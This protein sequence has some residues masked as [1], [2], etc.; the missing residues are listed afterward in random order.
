MT[1]LMR[2]VW[3][4]LKN[5]DVIMIRPNKLSNSMQLKKVKMICVTAL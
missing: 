1:Y 4:N 3:S 2:Q 5:Y